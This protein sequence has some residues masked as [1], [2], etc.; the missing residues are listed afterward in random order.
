MVNW[1]VVPLPQDWPLW[2]SLA[3]SSIMSSGPGKTEQGQVR[4]H[5]LSMRWLVRFPLFSEASDT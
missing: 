4:Q 1:N 5:A 2:I 3:P